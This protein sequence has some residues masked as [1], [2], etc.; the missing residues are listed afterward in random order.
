MRAVTFYWTL[1]TQANRACG[2]AFSFLDNVAVVLHIFFS[3]HFFFVFVHLLSVLQTL[4]RC[5]RQ[6]DGGGA[7]GGD[8]GKGSGA[9]GSS[10]A[11]RKQPSDQVMAMYKR[12]SQRSLKR[13][14]KEKG[15]TPG[16]LHTKMKMTTVKICFPAVRLITGCSKHACVVGNVNALQRYS[17]LF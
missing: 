7:V 6:T 13:E 16:S 9:K 5:Q 8:S 4:A 17:G 14:R 15:S 1:A 3:T 10:T 12:R 2:R 11:A